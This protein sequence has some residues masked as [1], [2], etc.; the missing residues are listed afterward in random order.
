[1]KKTSYIYESLVSIAN[2]FTIPR[3][4]L[5]DFCTIIQLSVRWKLSTLEKNLIDW[6]EK[7]IS[8]S[9][10]RAIIT[11]I[12]IDSFEKCQCEKD[13]DKLRGG[14]VEALVIGIYGG[15]S[16]LDENNFGWGANVMVKDSSG[17][18]APIRYVCSIDKPLD[19]KE[20]CYSDEKRETV[21]FGFYRGEK[22]KFFECKAQ[23]RGVGC[24]D[25]KYMEKLSESLSN[26]EI[27]HNIYFVFATSRTNIDILRRSLGN[28]GKGFQ[29]INIFDLQQRKLSF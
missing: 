17:K 24:I 3:K 23:S 29:F 1:M 25:I 22:G 5:V 26:R 18:P 16:I 14:I 13:I 4:Y 20:T 8:V 10:E 2:H 6:K 11:Q 28:R 21:D 19:N 9:D 27:R 7:F 12:V 15:T